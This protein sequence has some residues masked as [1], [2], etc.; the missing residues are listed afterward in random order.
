MD[1]EQ[2][3]LR[4]FC[5]LENITSVQSSKVATRNSVSMAMATS[6]HSSSSTL[7]KNMEP[8]AAYM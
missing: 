8:M 4:L 7:A 3:F 1:K 2:H 5:D 6:P